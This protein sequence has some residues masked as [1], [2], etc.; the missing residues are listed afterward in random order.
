MTLSTTAEL[1]FSDPSVPGFLAQAADEDLDRLGFGVIGFDADGLVRRY[2]ALESKA[3]GLSPERVLA[4]SLFTM[5]APC[6]NNSLVAQRFAQ[7]AEQ[8]EALDATL[9]YVL[10]LRMRP[11]KVQLRLLATPGQALRYVLVRRA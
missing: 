9:D 7:A 11:Q 4:R 8:G 3:A 5:V 10:T 2:N 6:M 1:R